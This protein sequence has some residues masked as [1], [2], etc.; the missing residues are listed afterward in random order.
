MTRTGLTLIA[1]ALAASAARPLFSP[2]DWWA[3]RSTSD[4]RISSDGEWVVYVASWNDRTSDET[5]ANIWAVSS[6]ARTRR[7]LTE[8]HWRDSSPRWSPDNARVAWLSD[9]SGKPQIWVRPLEPGPE[10]QVTNLDRPPLSLAWSPDGASFAFTALVPSR[11]E[12]P[13][14]AP[15]GILPRVRRAREGYVQ[16]FVV[17]A[18]GG[19]PRRVS[20]R[21]LDY[22]G[23]PAWMPDGR[24]ILAARA[25]GEIDSVR[26]SD[27]AVKTLTSGEGRN[28][29]PVPSSDG[30]KIAWL[31][32]ERKPQ[33]YA[34]RKLW[35]MNADGSRVKVLTGSL[36]RDISDPQWSSDSRT[37]YFRADDRGFSHVY[38]ARNDGTVRQVTNAAERLE[39]FSLADNGRAVVVRSTP[40]ESGSLF[41]FTVDRVSQPVVLA[42]P[43]EHLLAEREIAV[44]EEIVYPSAGNSIQ[45]WLIKPPGFDAA[46][47]YPL[48]L[49][50]RDNPRSMYGTDFNLRAQIF[51]ARGFVVLCVNPRGSP[52]YG[53]TFGN[54]LATRYPGDDYD[55]L[56]LGVDFALSKG[57]IDPARLTVVG[58]LLAAWTIGH[59]GRFHAAVA[60]RPVADWAVDIA[61]APD[62]Y[63]HATEW[64][65]ALPWEDPDRYVKHSPLFFAA[66]F[67]TPTL[68][69]AG[70]P[71]PQS[72]QIYFALQAR[73]VDSALV[74]LG[75]A[76]KPGERVLELETILR[77]F[78][79]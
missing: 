23:E 34:V 39:G 46:K 18:T 74:R 10:T 71:D 1:A 60:R 16:I 79:R 78:T 57:Y 8:G 38:A 11:T 53:E 62:G 19:T 2:D 15:P 64:L 55:D 12:P 37:V 36:D 68:V 41:T 43:N 47:K 59:T 58:G 72:D 17:P 69:L 45:G 6:N 14:W 4:P 44:P 22:T 42:A 61:T 40:A 49:D 7:Q 56:M 67:K 28:Q 48:L 27:G 73:K 29:N 77:W 9:R 35:V 52:G 3:W 63:R 21:D 76:G 13:A 50:I 20:T 70:N 54:L 24:S 65:G 51:A 25:D 66:N 31:A 75:P 30:G 33:S 32:T 26:I 5:F